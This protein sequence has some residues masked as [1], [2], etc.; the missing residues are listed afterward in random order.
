MA[1]PRYL[2]NDLFAFA[3]AD[4]GPLYTALLYAFGEA[5]ER[6]LTSL[7]LDDVREHLA[8]AG[9]VPA[10]DDTELSTALQ[11][12]R[13]WQLVDAGQNHSENYRTAHEY[14]RR[15][16]QYSLTRNG[17]AAL[18]G[19][20]AAVA[21]LESTGGLQTAVLDAIADVL[22]RLARLANGLP[23]TAETS[24]SEASG[25]QRRSYAAFQELSS[26]LDALRNGVRT[27]NSDLQR[28]LRADE[29]DEAVFGEVKEATV[30]YLDDYV[31]R[32]DDRTAR[33]RHG[34]D[35]VRSAGM[36]RVL[37][38]ALAGAELPP[39]PHPD[40]R[41]AHWLDAAHVRWT[42]L[43]A[44][45]APADGVQPRAQLLS[46]TA[47]RAIVSL[48]Q[49]VDR[50]RTARR[51]PSSAQADLRR[52]AQLF[53]TAPGDDDLHRL[54]RAAFGLHPSRHTHLGH[55]D[56]E[57][58]PTGLSWAEAEAVPVSALLRETGQTE[59][60]A[61][62]SRVRDV[63]E[64]RA[65]RAARARAER[66]SAEQAI[67]AL[68]TDGPVRISRLTE[69]DADAFNAFLELLGRAVAGP[70]R[71]GRLHATSADGRIEVTLTLPGDEARAVLRTTTGALDCPDYELTIAA[72]TRR[73]PAL[74]GVPA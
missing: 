40:E 45:F 66:A 52:L 8:A 51:R 60:F 56:P 24:T 38:A 2:P 36:E 17:E 67:R 9:W 12:L 35:R 26:H 43:E 30:R 25:Q 27:F 69:L 64:L 29:V 63:A 32:L 6:L 42:G 61:R 19:H 39:H 53:A 33:I 49:V 65:A 48:L 41:D 7:A 44:W 4:R 68:G 18:A 73:A 71:A 22:D 23:D 55:A 37:R 50:M 54:W 28:L 58:V 5:N 1:A 21:A 74:T 70:P 10:L 31:T 57:L 62:P 16:L 13:N 3:G 72:S 15:N 34:I 20:Q 46:A 47:R 59:K 14:E 11:Q